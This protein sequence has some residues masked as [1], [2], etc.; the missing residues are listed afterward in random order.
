MNIIRRRATAGW[1][2]IVLLGVL[3]ISVLGC[4]AADPGHATATAWASAVSV[5]QTAQAHTA[6]SAATATV[7]NQIA[8]NIGPTDSPTDSPVG[9]STPAPS[10]TPVLLSVIANRDINVRSG[11]STNYSVL[12]TLKQNASARIVGLSP[13]R[14][15]YLTEYGWVSANLVQ[16]QG[17]VSKAPVVTPAAPA[18]T[19]TATLAPTATATPIIAAQPTQPHVAV[20]VGAVCNDG[21]TSTATGSGA[22]SHHKGVA[23]WLYR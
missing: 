3:C 10:H 2:V 17:D 19:G 4:T 6:T 11:P 16:P 15:W 20:R 14:Q 9:L 7:L 13:D 23:Y 8:G 12:G 21:T 5:A 22:C 18:P 1:S